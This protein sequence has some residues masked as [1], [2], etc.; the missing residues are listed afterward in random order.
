VTGAASA[1]RAARNAAA[2]LI[3]LLCALFVCWH[4]ARYSAPTA[5]LASALGVTP[6]LAIGPSLWRGSRHGLVA[7]TLLTVPYLGYGLM[8]VLANPG[9]RL[10]AGALVLL[11]FALFV[12]LLACLRVNRPSAAAPSGR[13]AP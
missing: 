6:W 1:R 11:A 8:E 3:A 13:T 4:A 2:V 12:A 7:A 5:A 9:V 10:Y